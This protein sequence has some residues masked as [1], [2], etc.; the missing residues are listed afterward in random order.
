MTV[1]VRNARRVVVNTGSINEIEVQF[2]AELA[3]YV[4]VYAGSQLDGTLTQ[5]TYGVHY[6]LSGIGPNATSFIVNIVDP[7]DW[8]VSTYP[9]FAVFVD[10]PVDQQSDI[11]LGGTFGDRF[12]AALDRVV[13]MLQSLND[14]QKRSLMMPVVDTVDKA[15]NYTSE[16]NTI[17]GIDEAGLTVN[18]PLTD[19]DTLLAYIAAAEAAAAA[20]IA[21][22]G[23]LRF[24]SLALAQAGEIV[25]STKTIE[26]VFYDPN[27]SVPST[28]VGGAKYARKSLA[29]ITSD[30]NPVRSYFRHNT[31]R[32][33]PDGTV[34]AVNGGYFILNEKVTTPEMFGA[35]G[36]D[37]A[38]DGAALISAFQFGHEMRDNIGKTYLIDN[39]TV[40]VRHPFSF[41]GV[42]GKT[43]FV[44]TN[45]GG[46]AGKNGFN[47]QVAL[48]APYQSVTSFVNA[49]VL[50]RG[51]N[52]GTG[53]KTP[54][55]EGG[56]GDALFNAVH[57]KF[58]F[59]RMIFG[60]EVIRFGGANLV[61]NF[62]WMNCIHSGESDNSEF[63][64]L[65]FQQPFYAPDAA[66]SWGDKINTTGLRLAGRTGADGSGPVRNPLIDHVLAHGCGAPFRTDGYVSTPRWSN[67]DTFANYYGGIVSTGA[68]STGGGPS[69]L[70]EASIERAQFNGIAGAC[71]FQSFDYMT[72]DDA[73]MTDTS[74]GAGVVVDYAATWIG[75]EV[76][77]EFRQLT[78]NSP[79][80]YAA[81]PTSDN[82]HRAIKARAAT[83]ASFPSV[84]SVTEPF[85]INT[86]LAPTASRFTKVFEVSDISAINVT[87]P[88]V[89][90]NVV[91]LIALTGTLFPSPRV[92]LQAQK[93]AAITGELV[94]LGVGMFWVNVIRIAA[95]VTGTLRA[96]DNAT[97]N[98]IFENAG[99]SQDRITKNESG[100]MTQTRV[101]SGVASPSV[102]GTSIYSN[103]ETTF[104]YSSA[105]IEPPATTVNVRS[106]AVIWGNARPV[107]GTQGAFRLF[108]DASLGGT[109][110][111]ELVM[112]G[113]WK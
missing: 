48:T 71:K 26:T 9:R 64:G 29:D 28:L 108:S 98:A 47:V 72:I 63:T 80:F 65:I 44:F 43:S 105:F 91:D 70:S 106:S 60:G 54:V 45:M 59:D 51:A 10:Y 6:S 7:L 49:A 31:D 68:I 1:P 94:T 67:I 79:R 24:N 39:L 109:V 107:S 69:L 21:A 16:P 58:V 57:P 38:K 27:Y 76:V 25:A 104:T 22:V 40:P 56:N 84:I 18:I 42:A 11:G 86:A 4:K 41:E 77:D 61:T 97:P 90:G 13:W 37:A 12:E 32:Y 85:I 14:R 50:V 55:N 89:F 113:R 93:T 46:F 74:F 30:G 53:I 96:T 101:I 5:L 35:V 15:Y 75:I 112:I 36:G 100:W 110:F 88:F 81:R 83:S 95:P 111:V 33:M 34:D 62:G 20:A 3:I 103:T 73:D 17:L 78:I 87:D 66:A 82:D 52:G 92:T 99:A 102:L 8:D 2:P 23:V 19:I